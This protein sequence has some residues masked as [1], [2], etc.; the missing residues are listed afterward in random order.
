[1]NGKERSSSKS[2]LV[3]WL[4]IRLII[5]TAAFAFFIVNVALPISRTDETYLVSKPSTRARIEYVGSGSHSYYVFVFNNYGAAYLPNSWITYDEAMQ[6]QNVPLS[7]IIDTSPAHIRY[8]G[9]GQIVELKVKNKVIL[10]LDKTKETRSGYRVFFFCAGGFL[11]LIFVLTSIYTVRG[12]GTK[13]GKQSGPESVKE[14]K[15]KRPPH[16]N[17]P[18]D[19]SSFSGNPFEV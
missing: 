13:Q 8:G 2:N 7:V 18:F 14:K 19:G 6:L 12:P 15:K 4:M 3:L 1:M 5:Y 17:N 16:D 9:L 11:Y 10:S